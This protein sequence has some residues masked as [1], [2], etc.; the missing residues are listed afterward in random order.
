MLLNLLRVLFILLMAAVGWTYL[1]DESQF[2]GGQTWLTLA[3][4]L[5]LGVFAISVDILAPR[6]KLSVFSGTFFGQ[7][8]G[9]FVAYALSF[10]VRLFVDQ[11]ASGFPGVPFAATNKRESLIMFCTLI[12]GTCACYLAI[13]IVLQT[14][15]DFRFIIPYVEFSKQ[16]KGPRPLIL[17]TSALIDGRIAD[18]AHAGIF[19]T[20]LVVPAFVL[21]ELQRVADSGDKL[22][23][24]RGRRGLDVLG[25]LQQEKNL[26]VRIYESERYDSKDIAVDQALMSL[27]RELNGRVLTTDYN[28]N[29]VAQLTGVEVLNLN[30]LA[31]ALKVEVLPGE[32]TIV[33]V[34][35]PGEEQNQ[36]VGFLDDGTMVVIEHGKP[37]VG[38]DVE[39]IVTNTR[40]TAAGK[41]IFGRIPDSQKTGESRSRDSRSANTHSADARPADARPADARPAD[42]R[43]ADV[44]DGDSRPPEPR[45][46][47]TRSPE[48]RPPE[49]RRSRN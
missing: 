14:K 38:Q 35:R 13:S 48:T 8:V 19:E 36:G 1:Q 49:S 29:K 34:V 28:L 32:S 6:K 30:E 42:A 20:Q 16:T 11:I 41:M 18:V 24:N 4:A 39:I 46:P 12:L 23:R 10:V 9:V 5:S 21:R 25:K 45:L 44:T 40:Q 7:L 17:D 22:K 47:E 15:D 37:F 33:R 27:A 3:I 31:N 43:P 26:D 2:L